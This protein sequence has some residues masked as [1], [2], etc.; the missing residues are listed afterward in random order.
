VLEV[1]ALLIIVFLAGAFVS[2]FT[3]CL[4]RRTKVDVIAFDN[5]AALDPTLVPAPA[6][7]PEPEPEPEP[8]SEKV[9]I[10]SRLVAAGASIDEVTSNKYIDILTELSSL[11]TVKLK[12]LVCLKK[13]NYGTIQRFNKS[14]PGDQLGQGPYAVQA[15]FVSHIKV[16][17]PFDL[18]KPEDIRWAVHNLL[19]LAND[20]DCQ[21]VAH[22]Y[23]CAVNHDPSRYPQYD[24]A[25][26]GELETLAHYNLEHIVYE[27]REG[28][29]KGVQI[30]DNCDEW[31][32]EDALDGFNIGFEGVA[33]PDDFESV[34]ILRDHKYN[35]ILISI[36]GDKD[37]KAT[38]RRFPLNSA[39]KA[40]DFLKGMEGSKTGETPL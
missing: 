6:T 25:N 2:R 38:H 22:V 14:L 21:L 27:V 28:E 35:G 32:Y 18:S 23:E 36:T 17:Q 30:I 10:A 8:E 9:P 31:D 13:T 40:L 12:L 4:N 1:F 5:D 39:I 11:A 26:L 3:G 33:R 7:E 37:K 15:T 16:E 19:S 20:T 29:N 24:S 34:E